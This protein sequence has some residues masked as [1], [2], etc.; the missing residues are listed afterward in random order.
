MKINDSSGFSL[1]EVLVATI[2]LAFMV[3]AVTTVSDN[4]LDATQTVV[5]EDREYLQVLTAFSRIKRD[6]EHIYSPLY[7]ARKFTPNP[8]NPQDFQLAQYLSGKFKEN[9]N[10]A[11]A[12]RSGLP[13]PLFEAEEKSSLK[14][15]T[16]TNRRK[17]EN[18][19]ESRF[20][21]VSYRLESNESEEE[22]KQGLFNLMRE[23]AGENIYI[24]DDTLFEKPK[25]FPLMDNVVSLT[26]EYWDREKR[27]WREKITEVPNGKNIIRGVKIVLEWKD[28]EGVEHIE[29]RIF[30][31]LFPYFIPEDPT[32]EQTQVPAGSA[33]PGATSLPN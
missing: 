21:W 12:I 24:T 18:S 28:K 7:F 8:D 20:A 5:N 10:F 9:D 22:S 11:F 1:I 27:K 4:A 16:L 6:I 15:F 19:K 17:L 30:R 2:M 23:Q 29:Q 32:Q 25:S 3:Y 33:T 26:F 13:V 14:I 31:P